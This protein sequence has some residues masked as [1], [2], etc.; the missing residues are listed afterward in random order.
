MSPC[1]PSDQVG[2]SESDR[3]GSVSQS[4]QAVTDCQPGIKAVQP[5]GE[6]QAL[7]SPCCL[8]P[9]LS[10]CNLRKHQ[11][12][13]PGRTW[14]RSVTSA[15]VVMVACPSEPVWWAMPGLSPW[16]MAQLLG[17][18]PLI[19][20]ERMGLGIGVKYTSALA[21]VTRRLL[22]AVSAHPH[23]RCLGGCYHHNGA[24]LPKLDRVSLSETLASGL[25][26][27]KRC[28]PS[29]WWIVDGHELKKRARGS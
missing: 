18:S 29:S 19:S 4:P 10:I 3:I 13:L 21:Y 17:A 8:S 7:G 11:R 22:G 20:Y 28:C 26:P 24:C 16:Q 6:A 25:T 12:A 23:S 14:L 9:S 27:C 5:G 2:P 15:M 1:C